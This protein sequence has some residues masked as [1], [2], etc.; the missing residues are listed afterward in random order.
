MPLEELFA[1]RAGAVGGEAE[2][3]DAAVERSGYLLVRAED[4]ERFFPP[5]YAPVEG[6]EGEAPLAGAKGGKAA[7]EDAD[8]AV[9]AHMVTVRFEVLRP[10]GEADLNVLRSVRYMEGELE[11]DLGADLEDLRRQGAD[12]K[13]LGK[14]IDGLPEELRGALREA[15]AQLNPWKRDADAAFDEL[16]AMAERSRAGAEGGADAAESAEAPAG[17]A[18][19]SAGAADAPESDTGASADGPASGGAGYNAERSVERLVFA[20]RVERSMP[21]NALAALLRGGAPPEGVGAANWPW[22]CYEA[23]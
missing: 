20:R 4:A 22:F 11:S 15:H 17:A 16:R 1:L 19:A 14:G 10:R 9:V 3:A 8:D 12:L 18:E 13:D 21:F 6:E 5:G 23:E 7:G 2:V